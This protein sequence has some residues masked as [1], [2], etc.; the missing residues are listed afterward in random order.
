MAKQLEETLKRASEEQAIMMELFAEIS[1]QEQGSAPSL[2]KGKRRSPED[3]F[4]KYSC[5]YCA[6]FYTADSTLRRHIKLKHLDIG[7]D[8][9]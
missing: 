2:K 8:P 9:P 4:Q 1:K 7:D 5:Q 6:K 3:A